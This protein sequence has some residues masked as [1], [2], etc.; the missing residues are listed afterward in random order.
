[1]LHH[2]VNPIT[3]KCDLW[4]YIIQWALLH[5]SMFS[6]TFFI[7]CALLHANVLSS[8]CPLT[9]SCCSLID[10]QWQGSSSSRPTAWELPGIN[11]TQPS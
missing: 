4:C 11:P 3:Q 1:L 5:T 7:K 6:D 8:L 9:K 10:R 2:S